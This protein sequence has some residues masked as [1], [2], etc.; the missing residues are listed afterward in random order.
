MTKNQ[1]RNKHVCIYALPLRKS[2]K[3]TNRSV[4]KDRQKYNKSTTI[5]NKWS[6]SFNEHWET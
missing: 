3:E 2:M 4:K 6:A 1:K 5:H